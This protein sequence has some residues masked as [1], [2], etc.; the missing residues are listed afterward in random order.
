MSVVSGS[1]FEAPLPRPLEWVGIVFRYH[2][3][4]PNGSLQDIAG[5]TNDE[6]NV[7]GLMPHPERAADRLLGGTDGA[8]IFDSMVQAAEL[9]GGGTR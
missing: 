7:V 8:L 4:N 1:S 9:F 6:R 2:D 5:I 3:R